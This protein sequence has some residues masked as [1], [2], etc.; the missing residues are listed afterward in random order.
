MFPYDGTP[1][2]I[3]LLWTYVSVC[4]MNKLK[5]IKCIIG[6]A[7]LLHSRLIILFHIF[8]KKTPLNWLYSSLIFLLLI[9]AHLSFALLLISL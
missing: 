7:S 4:K 3:V 5:Y 8:Q 1:W 6:K 9:F 2:S